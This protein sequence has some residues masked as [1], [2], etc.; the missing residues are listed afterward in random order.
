MFQTS[1]PAGKRVT[2]CL[3]TKE[4]DLKHVLALFVIAGA[5]AAALGL[6]LVLRII[7]FE[8]FLVSVVMLQN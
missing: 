4:D 1:A 5:L 6:G 2:A 3:D 7:N 8:T